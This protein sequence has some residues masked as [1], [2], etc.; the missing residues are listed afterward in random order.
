[1]LVLLRPRLLEPA[2]FSG[3]E[4]GIYIAMGVVA[5]HIC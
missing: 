5:V 1:M 3:N 2:V 4:S